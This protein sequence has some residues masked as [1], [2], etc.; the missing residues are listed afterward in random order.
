M[1]YSTNSYDN[2]ESVIVGVE[3]NLEQRLADFT[4]KHFYQS[5]LNNRIY[6][7]PEID[8]YR[9]KPDYLAERISDLDGLAETLQKLGVIVHRPKVIDKVTPFKTPHFKSELS[10]ASN[11]RDLTL[12]YKDYIIETPT[13][14][15][16]RYFENLSMYELFQSEMLEGAKWISAPQRELTDKTIDLEHWTAKR[17]YN[18]IPSNYVMAIDAAQFLRMDDDIIVNINSYNHWL[19]YKWIENIVD[20]KFHPIFIA[21]NHIDGSIVQLNHDTFLVN[22]KHKDDIMDAI[23]QKFRHFKFLYPYDETSSRIIEDGTDIGIQLA[24]ERGMDINVLSISPKRVL[25]NQDAVGTIKVLE[26]NGFDVIPIQLRH[27]EIF[28]GGIHCSTLDLRRG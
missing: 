7:T 27:S 3:L 13:Y 19:G 5:N 9:I 11:V 8:S 25:V 14:V 17:D 21:D 15:Q 2:L 4:F 23:P 20:A 28:G 22:P 6:E 1:I 18:N 12:I 24:S 10:S 16:N 26:E